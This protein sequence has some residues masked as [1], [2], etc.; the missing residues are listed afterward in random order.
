MR[1][2]LAVDLGGT[3]TKAVAFDLDREAAVGVSQAGSNVPVIVSGN[4][5]VS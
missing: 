5:V 2:I 1:L 3:Y 4:E